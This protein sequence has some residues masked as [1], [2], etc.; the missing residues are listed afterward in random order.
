M[1]VTKEYLRE[2]IKEA[3]E[4]AMPYIPQGGSREERRSNDLKT[5]IKKLERAK[6]TLHD[7]TFLL[8]SAI[9]DISEGSLLNSREES[10][11][12]GNSI[13]KTADNIRNQEVPNLEKLIQALSSYKQS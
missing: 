3:L 5:Q 10:R 1:K 8:D 7:M 9:I 4:E 6:K 11:E 2:L 13:G 12:I